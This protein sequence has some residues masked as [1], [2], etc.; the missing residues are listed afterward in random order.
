MPLY[1]GRA[2]ATQSGVIAISLPI[3]LPLRLSSQCSIYVDPTTAVI[4]VSVQTDPAGNW[5]GGLAIPPQAS[6]AGA[7]LALQGFLGP[8][9]SPWGADMT[10][11]VRTAVTN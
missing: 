10:N 5:A 11:G 7:Q 8:T 2:S 3:A 9:T 1:V 6:L 4:A